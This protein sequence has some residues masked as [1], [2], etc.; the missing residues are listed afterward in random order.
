MLRSQFERSF[1]FLMVAMLLALP[2]MAQLAQQA[3]PLVGT[4]YAGQ[5]IQGASVALS[6]DGNTAIVGGPSDSGSSGAAWIWV[7]SAGVWTQ[8]AK[9]VG[10]GVVG[11]Y[12]EQ[13]QS[14]ALSADGNTALV[15]GEYDNSRTG[16]VWVFTRTGSN[17]T[18]QTKLVGT[19]NIGESYQGSSVA[20]SRDASVAVVGGFGDNSYIGAVWV[21]TQDLTTHAWTQQ[22][23][24]TGTGASSAFAEQGQSVAVSPDGDTIIVGAPNDGAASQGAVWFFK[25]PGITYHC[26]ANCGSSSPTVAPNPRV[27]VWT[28]QGNKIAATAQIETMGASVA[29]SGDGLTALAGAPDAGRSYI[30][31]V[32]VYAIKPASPSPAPPDNAQITVTQQAVLTATGG[33]GTPALGAAVALSADGN[34]AFA[35]GSLDSAAPG[36]VW[37]FTRTGTAWSQ[38]GSKLVAAGNT[39]TAYLGASLGVSANARTLLAGAWG[40]SIVPT[41][42]V[43]AAWVFAVPGAPDLVPSFDTHNFPQVTLHRGDVGDQYHVVVGNSGDG[44]TDGSTV[45]AVFTVPSGLTATGLSGTNWSCSTGTLT[46]TRTDVLA[47]GAAYEGLTLTV[48]VSSTAPASITVGVAVS[49][50]GEAAGA[51]SNDSVTYPYF[52]PTYSDLTVNLSHSGSFT[53]GQVGALYTVRVHN[54]GQAP[55]SGM[56]LASVSLPAG[57][58]ATAISGP[59]WGSCSTGTASCT[60]GDSLAAG[61]SYPAITLTVN[62]GAGASGILSPV[63]TTSGGGELITTNDTFTDSTTI[64][65]GA[66]LVIT[67]AIAGQLTHGQTGAAYVLTVTNNGAA[68]SAGQVRVV[69]LVPAGFNVTAMS[70][71]GWTC[72]YWSQTCV[73]GDALASGASYP[74]IRMTFSIP[75]SAG[76]YISTFTVSGG[77]DVNT[78][79][80][81]AVDT[82][83]V[84]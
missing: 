64:G 3:G 15:G 36:A 47:G 25:R 29:I 50:G 34:T 12:A 71:T 24:L 4:P 78:G 10:T 44:P 38:V 5:S 52:L 66:D 37:E 49:G 31:K 60:R 30:G 43:G 70:G 20:L 27:N 28:Q 35:G 84:H 77:G 13:G 9:L 57:L 33:V 82:Q 22:A 61:A 19:G 51:T 40:Y 41:G 1:Y 68:A 26:T 80:N 17:W 39:G 72:A 76:S 14:V 75:G 48:N 54:A 65:T 18:Q 16:A 74:P 55:T 42:E 63:A 8:Q 53:P 32:Y 62:V 23:K 2:G 81:Q 56:V 6:A 7:R 69:G 59:G 58:T 79:N 83:T 46:C 21:F 67:A 45:S 11:G 73:R